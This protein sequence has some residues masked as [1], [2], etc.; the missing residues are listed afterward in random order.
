MWALNCLFVGE[1]RIPSFLQNMLVPLAFLGSFG[2]A[3]AVSADQTSIVEA[4]TRTVNDYAWHLDHP[5][6]DAVQTAELFADLFAPD[7]VL[8]APDDEPVLQT[9]AGRGAIIERYL[10]SSA[11]TRFLHLTSNIRVTPTSDITATG[12]SY[13]YFQAHG[14]GGSMNDEGAIK[15]ILENRDDYRMIGQ[16][17]KFVRRISDYRWFSLD[18]MISPPEPE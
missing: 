7:G 12:T 8:V 10:D 16:K 6:D 14:I 2:T 3:S 5:N 9:Y 17:C 11:H 15:G 13:L 4:C 1:I 18:G